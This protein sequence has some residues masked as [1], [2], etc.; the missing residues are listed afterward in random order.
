MELVNLT[1]TG[2]HVSKVCLGTMMFGGQTSEADSFAIMDEALAAGVNFFDTANIYTKGASEKIVGKWMKGKREQVI[3]ATKV[4][5]PTGAGPNET[6][7]S[8]RN[9]LAACERSLRSLDTDYI[10]LYYLHQPDYSTPLEETLDALSTLVR[11]GK[12]RY[13]ALS[14]FAA[15][16]VAKIRALCE[17]Y[18]LVP[19]AVSQ[20][21]YNLITRGIEPE[22]IPCL[23]D[24]GMGL[25][26]YNPI[27]GG[28]LTGKHH[29]DQAPAENT[30][31]SNNKIYYDRYWND[32]SFAAVGELIQ[33]AKV[34]GMSILE[35]SLRWCMHQPGV[36]SVITGVSRIEQLRQNL[37]AL[38]GGPLPW[39]AL[40]ACDEV[41][42]RLSGSRFRYNK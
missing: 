3:L 39:E 19:P 16:Q 38:E 17:K 32:D 41:W 36:T 28:L 7:L 21:V 12:V 24:H 15:W 27:A 6:G 33:V 18:H 1:G 2:L 20:N 13:A 11:Q 4:G 8:R 5:M 37:A 40:A 29:G 42:Q 26:I 25:V 10:D 35:F 34:H 22:L 14:N 9:I 23:Q 30:R 31:F